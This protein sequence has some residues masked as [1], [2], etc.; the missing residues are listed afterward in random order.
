[1]CILVPYLKSH[2]DV[3]C[4]HN[5]AIHNSQGVE[6]T[7]MYINRQMNKQKMGYIHSIKYYSAFKKGEKNHMPQHK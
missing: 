5:K 7:Q 2:V 3:H 4:V 1:M 6:A